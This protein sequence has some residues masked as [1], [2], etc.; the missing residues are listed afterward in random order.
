MNNRRVGAGVRT[1][2]DPC[3]RTAAP[4][5]TKM[6]TIPP[7]ARGTDN[8]D[9][10]Y[11]VRIHTHTRPSVP[12]PIYDGSCYPVYEYKPHAYIVGTPGTCVTA[13]RLSDGSRDRAP[14]GAGVVR[15]QRFNCRARYSLCGPCLHINYRNR[16]CSTCRPKRHINVARPQGYREDEHD[17][18]RYYVYQPFRTVT[19]APVVERNNA[20]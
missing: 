1:T 7:R 11:I 9:V 2:G 13:I 20:T 19:V 10:R 17:L 6:I 3:S 5:R 18:I 12:P 16:L 8:P 15:V 14:D 4:A